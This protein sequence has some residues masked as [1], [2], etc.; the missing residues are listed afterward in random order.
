MNARK[1]RQLQFKRDVQIANLEL[2]LVLL[3][4]G[5]KLRFHFRKSIEI[6]FQ[7][8]GLDIDRRCGKEIFVRFVITL[9]DTA[10]KI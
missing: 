8:K 2:D 4:T 7:W 5:S 9:K 1:K 3:L 6:N 10:Q